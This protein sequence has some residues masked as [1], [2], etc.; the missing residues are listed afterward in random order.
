MK[1][2]SF[3]QFLVIFVLMFSIIYSLPNFFGNNIP[4]WLSSINANQMNLGLDLKG[5]VHFLLEVNLDEVVANKSKKLSDDI[6]AQLRSEE[7]RYKNYNHDLYNIEVEFNNNAFYQEA[8]NLINNNYQNTFDIVK[9]GNN[10][11]RI[12]ISSS[13]INE[14]RIAAIKQNTT[15]FCFSNSNNN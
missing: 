7:I 3:K 15:T 12:T 6:R 14:L 9:V 4:S 5:G 10:I 13:T 1:I 2:L 11:M 8:E